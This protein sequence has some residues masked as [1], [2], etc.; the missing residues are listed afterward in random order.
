[1][2]TV[3]G[4]LGLWSYVAAVLTSRKQV[5][6]VPVAGDRLEV[7]C[8]GPEIT[9]RVNGVDKFV[10]TGITQNLTA[11]QFGVGMADL[12]TRFDNLEIKAPP[13]P[14]P[15]LIVQEVNGFRVAQE[16]VYVPTRAAG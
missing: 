7:Q 6:Y 14:T 4:V 5:A 11:T 10:A 13:V 9:V 16:L 2:S 15:Y 12:I 8:L 1:V 3:D